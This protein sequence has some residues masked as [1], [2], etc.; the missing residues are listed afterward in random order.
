MTFSGF[1][2]FTALLP[3]ILIDD[4]GLTP[5]QFA[6][7]LLVQTAS[8]ISGNLVVSYLSTRISGARLV[9][10]ALVLLA[11]SGLGFAVLPQLFP[12]SVLAIMAPVG[13]WMLALAFISPSTTAAAMSG[14]GAIAGAAGAM[15]GFF[16][17]GGGFV[18]S[19]TAGTL[20]PD[21]R[22]ALVVQLPSIAILAI[23]VALIDRRRRR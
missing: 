16:Q 6:M 19:L 12:G 4:L 9:E 15:T 14:F 18:G 17:V 2:G 11:I 13:I 8:F 5:F 23:G 21:A 3:F 1:H 10:I 22:T 20:F 7:A